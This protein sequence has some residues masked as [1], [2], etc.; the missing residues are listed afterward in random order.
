[1]FPLRA[2]V[3]LQGFDFRKLFI[4][5][6]GW[7]HHTQNLPMTAEGETYPLSAVAQKRGLVVFICKLGESQK[8]PDYNIRRKIEKQVAKSVH[9]HILIF[10]DS[11]QK[12]QIWQWVKR[13]PGKPIA[14]REHSYHC[15]QPG[16]SLLQKCQTIAFGFEEEEDLT[17]PGVTGRTRAAFD[18]DRVTKKFYDRFKADHD[19]FYNF[20]KGI[21]DEELQRWY[22]SVMLNRLMFIYFIQKKGFL[23]NDLH[24]LRN[25][26]AESRK[27]GKDRF[28]SHFL[29]PLFFEGFAKTEGERS[30]EANHLLGKVPYLNGGLFLRHQIEEVHGRNIQIADLAFEK[31]FAFFDQYHWHLDERPLRADNEI[32][33]DVLGYIF[34][35]YVNQKQM[36][37]YYTKEDITEYISKNTIIPFLFDSARKDF[38][39][40][41]EEDKP[42]W[43][44]LQAEP[45]RY[46][47][48]AMKKGVDIPLPSEIAQGVDDVSRRTEWNK[49]AA[50]EY[51]LP[52]EIWREAVARRKR[53]EEVRGRM[54]KGELKDIND[55]ITYNLDIRQFAQDAIVNSDTPELLRAFWHG[56][57]KITVLDPTCGSGAFLFA[58]LNILEPLYEACLQRMESFLSDLERSGEKHRPEKFSDFRKVLQRVSQHPNP[59]YFILKSIIINNLFGV[60]I[61]EEATEICKLRLFLKMVAQVESPDHI[62]PLPDIDFNIRAANTLVGFAS[63]DDAKKGMEGDWVKLLELP[64]IEE[65][66]EIADRA[67]QKFRQMQTE[68]GMDSKDF[69]EAKTELQTRLGKLEEELNQYLAKEYGIDLRRKPDYEKWKSSHRPFHWFIEFFG[70]LK[71]GGFDVIIG[72]PPYVVYVPNK[73]KYEI[74]P[75]KYI[76]FPTKN[77]Y[78]FVFERSVSLGK[79][80]SNIGLIVQLTILSS[81]R[82]KSLQDLL[83]DRGS[84]YMLS[85]PRRPEAIFEGVEMPVVIVLSI[86]NRQKA[87]F[88]SRINRFYTE[89]R[90]FALSHSV[91]TDHTIRIDG[92]RIAK[93]GSPLE[94]QIFRKL[95]T[96]KQIMESLSTNNSRWGLYY[97][98]AC[99]YWVK[100]SKGLPF[101]K[102]NGKSIEPPHG[103]LIHF[104]DNKSCVFAFCLVNSSL[105]YWFYSSF[106]DCEHI[107]D[108]LIRRF[109]IPDSWEDADWQSIHRRLEQSINDNSQKKTINTKEGHIIEYLES[110]LVYSKS[111][112]DEI[113]HLLARQYR[114]DNYE[115]D[116]IKNYDIKYRMGRDGNEEGDD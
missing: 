89:E 31:V 57:E 109:R 22:V 98:E 41:F 68:Q 86:P 114:F 47:Y 88:T 20:L 112:I 19:A 79:S 78:S 33:P 1:M 102:R 32:N 30:P 12:S 42:V 60:D 94:A 63:L 40:G 96:F 48:D 74:K 76:T 18:V 111:I 62:E 81:E 104:Q 80:N 54:V 115:L 49:P 97:Q 53:C 27:S 65:K 59:R 99:R 87:L 51:A 46:I 17:L 56:I 69:S 77:L 64:K 43:Q 23:D 93:I 61:M 72:N 8:F 35:K 110:K 83:I 58:A 67:F 45:D 82:I 2:R 9:E 24:Y 4:E 85:F 11:S 39:P 38:K 55:L 100:A 95:T 29:C 26:L 92:Y 3:C 66:A 37:A 116:F 73:V 113:D 106:S 91:L 71:N 101:F 52:T 16:D 105:F 70:I 13:E 21:P 5:E 25:K 44:L 75:S 50:P 36:G 7:D 84:V 6:M 14:C 103:R 90:P 10:T 15:N 34:E 107:N 28:Y 108:S